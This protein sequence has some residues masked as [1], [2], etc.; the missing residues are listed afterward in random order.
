MS[1]HDLSRAEIESLADRLA[2]LEPEL[3]E[4]QR[5]LLAAIVRLAAAGLADPVL[6]GDVVTTTAR[7]SGPVVVEVTDAIP[8]IR[9]AFLDAFTPGGPAPAGGAASLPVTTPVRIGTQL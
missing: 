6:G 8:S 4:G 2:A 3:T 1:E 7:T 9:R 5:A